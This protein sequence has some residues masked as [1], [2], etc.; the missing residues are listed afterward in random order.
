[1]LQAEPVVFLAKQVKF[2]ALGTDAVNGVGEDLCIGVGYA[3]ELDNAAAVGFVDHVLKRGSGIRLV[4]GV[5]VVV[6]EAVVD[7]GVTKTLGNCQYSFRGLTAGGDGRG[8][9]YSQNVPVH[10]HAAA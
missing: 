10:N 3:V 9:S 2:Q 4:I 5:P 8:S 6:G 1:M 7:G